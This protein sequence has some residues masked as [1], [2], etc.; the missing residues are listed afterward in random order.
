MTVSLM[1]Q[2]YHGMWRK[3]SNWTA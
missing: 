3:S 2:F 1:M